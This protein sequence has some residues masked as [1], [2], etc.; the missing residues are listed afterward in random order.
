[1]L[2]YREYGQRVVL[3]YYFITSKI[4]A[5]STQRTPCPV[6][7]NTPLYIQFTPPAYFTH[8]YHP[9]SCSSHIATSKTPSIHHLFSIPVLTSTL[10]LIPKLI[11][12]SASTVLPP[13]GCSWLSLLC[14][15]Q[16]GVYYSV[17]SVSEIHKVG[18]ELDT[19]QHG[20]PSPAE[21]ERRLYSDTFSPS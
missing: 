17:A 12:E 5:R 15:L 19:T 2:D 11:S 1:M 21:R 18:I 4:L 20:E 16:N 6:A 10:T 9:F 14:A 8:C 3:L 13:V 7:L